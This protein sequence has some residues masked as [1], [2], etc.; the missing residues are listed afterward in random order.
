MEN[1]TV[2]PYLFPARGRKPPGFPAMAG[3]EF[4][5]DPY[6]FPARGRKLE[7]Y[8][9][10]KLS[11]TLVVDPYL[12]PARGRKPVLRSPRNHRGRMVDP[13]LFPARG[14]KRDGRLACL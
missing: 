11:C 4:P 14:R 6:L 5:V 3:N 13:Y 2:D 1:E 10:P 7:A 12:F 8:L 9:L